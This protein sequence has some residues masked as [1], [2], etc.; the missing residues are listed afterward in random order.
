VLF[1]DFESGLDPDVIAVPG[2]TNI[3]ITSDPGEVLDGSQSLYVETITADPRPKLVEL[4]I[5]GGYL[6]NQY[7]TLA[8]RYH[9]VSAALDE[10]E[11]EMIATGSASC[12]PKI[13]PIIPAATGSSGFLRTYLHL[14][15]CGDYQIY[16]QSKGAVDIILDD[17]SVVEGQGGLW[18]R[19]YENGIAICND[20]GTNQVLPYTPTWTLVD[21]EQQIEDYSF[22]EFG[23]SITLPN[24][25]GLVFSYRE[26]GL[27]INE[28][29]AENTDLN[30]DEL[31]EHEDWIEVY[32]AND[33]PLDLGGFTLSNEYATPAK[34]TFP[35]GTVIDA[36][37]FVLVWCDNETEEGPLHAPFTLD[38]TTSGEIG[39]YGPALTGSVELDAYSFG[40]QTADVSEGR[41]VD[42]GEPWIFFVRPTPDGSNQITA[43]DDAAPGALL[44]LQN[45]DDRHAAPWIY[46]QNWGHFSESG[47]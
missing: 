38:A 25:D 17:I 4:T 27:F 3:S 29:L 2:M 26:S 45:H 5:P 7:Y 9:V 20:S 14:G 1:C 16:L 12:D 21:G 42:G 44:L 30:G 11:L 28:F 36:N 41:E 23:A 34:F 35:A 31:G 19:R 43:V 8:M 40:P 6:A 32:N 13:S 22:W 37:G 18:A 15:G 33:I 10:T 46:L 24:R 39:L 47:Q